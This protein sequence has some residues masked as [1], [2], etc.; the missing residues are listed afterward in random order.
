MLIGAFC[1][2]YLPLR[3]RKIKSK[4]IL[5]LRGAQIISNSVACV[6]DSRRV[7]ER[8]GDLFEP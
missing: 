4:S 7:S 6:R 3:F 5:H 1:T 2:I 8:S